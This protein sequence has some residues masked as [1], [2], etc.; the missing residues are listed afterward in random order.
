MHTNKNYCLKSSKAHL[1]QNLLF[2]KM[3]H[4]ADKH[5]FL[6]DNINDVCHVKERKK[7][8]IMSTGNDAKA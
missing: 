1:L 6:S 2:W 5:L 4:T 7:E 3:R 8:Y